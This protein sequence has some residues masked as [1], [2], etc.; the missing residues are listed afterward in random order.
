MLTVW[1]I[2]AL[3]AALLVVAGMPK[4]S[5][6]A[7]V[8]MLPSW[9]ARPLGLVELAVGAWVLAAPSTAAFTAMAA[10]Y[11]LLTGAMILAMVRSEPDCGCFGVDPVKPGVSHLLL[12]VAF[13][14][15]GAAAAVAAGGAGWVAE[16]AL[17]R[18][19]VAGL[20]LLGATLLAELMSTAADLRTTRSNLRR[21]A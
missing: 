2:A 6:A 1:A 16:S 3:G 9:T 7:T 18:A 10:T 8:P 12:D 17:T 4:V 21:T 11:L 14:A 19:L 13:L 20:A 15:A 5:G